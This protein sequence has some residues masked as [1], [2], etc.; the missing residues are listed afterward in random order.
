MT[1]KEKERETENVDPTPENNDISL[2]TLQETLNEERKARLEMEEKV[3]DLGSRLTKTQ[4]ENAEYTRLFKANLPKFNKSFEDRW[5]SSPEETIR[6]EITHTVK[7]VDQQLKKL[8]IR[9]VN[10]DLIRRNPDWSKY[11]NRVMELGDEN[12]DLTWS[13]TGLTRLYQIAEAEQIKQE[14]DKYKANG[15]AESEKDRAFTEDSTPSAKGKKDS[16]L[17]SEQKR[18]SKNLGISEE[19]YGKMLE[20]GYG[21]R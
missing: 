21:T 8:E 7:P 13:E 11:E 16:S 12:P 18:I 20:E 1:E 5:E 3:K 14:Y 4:Q 17:T 15:K 6:D 2:E 9:Q 19:E 10:A